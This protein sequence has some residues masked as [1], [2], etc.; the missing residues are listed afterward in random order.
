MTRELALVIVL[1][2]AVVGIALMLWGWRRRSRRDAGIAVPIGVPAGAEIACFDGLYVATTRRDE[3]LDRIVAR[4]LG[5]RSRAAIQVAEGG[6]GLSLPGEQPVVLAASRLEGVG[7]AT[8]TID[9]VVERDGLVLV[10]WTDGSHHLDTYL[11]LQTEET[12]RLIEAIE[13]L[14]PSGAQTTGA[15]A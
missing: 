3:P 13:G 8:W 14:M 4:P 1:A 2:I 15:T 6:V 5:F 11:R 12:A 10:A 9:R 7:H